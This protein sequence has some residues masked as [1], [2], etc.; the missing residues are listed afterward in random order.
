MLILYEFFLIIYLICYLPILFIK[1]KWHSGFLERFG[2]FSEAIKERINHPKNIWIH[3][4][5]VGEVIAIAELIRRL[6]AKYP[7]CQ[8]VLSTSTKTGHQ[9]AL[10]KLSDKVV[11]LWSPLDFQWAVSAFIRLI[12]PKV[13]IVAETELWPNL[14]AGLHAQ[15]VPILLI[16]GRISDNSYGRY[17][18]IRW[19]M[20]RYLGYVS[21]LCM[22]S[23][24]DVKR[25]LAMGA[26]QDKVKNIGNVKFDDLPEDKTYLLE[27]FGFEHNDSL[28][29]A[30]STHPGEEDIVLRVFENI[31]KKFP[32]LRLVIAP[33]HVER[34]LDVQRIVEER[35]MV[36]VRFSQM[37]SE[38]RIPNS[39]VI[40]DTIGHLRA[41]YSLAT[42]V[43]VGKS[44]TV[45]GGHNIIEP[46]YFSKPVIV[47]PHM[48]N[49]RDVMIAFKNDKAVVEVKDSQ[50]FEST[51]D[52]LLSHPAEMA[53]LGKK[54]RQV[55]ARQQG[56]AARSV[57]IIS[58][59]LGKVL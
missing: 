19:F 46:A 37:K 51:V 36:P 29:I 35:G 33:R 21:V 10:E 58:R 18:A 4:V 41:L 40:V 8:I 22:Q 50:E 59:F 39:V 27:D 47:G 45:Q 55:I 24:L 56:A 26:P 30:G 9:L 28:W 6:K 14:F 49:F 44:L 11:I 52:R 34:V 15:S 43:F 32:S 23:E 1:G 48:Q 31:R 2:F 13:Y 17:L 3:A 7:D 54:A 57:E 16:N 42:L 53:E 12:K 5:S 20:K 38:R 25:I